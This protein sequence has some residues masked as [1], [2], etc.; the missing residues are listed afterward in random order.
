MHTDTIDH[1]I[2]MEQLQS[3]MGLSGTALKWFQSYI[4]HRI[5]SVLI[6]GTT[7][8]ILEL[9][10]GVPQGS[11]LGPLLF[12]IYTGPLGDLLCSLGINYHLYADDTQ[13]YLTFDLDDAPDMIKKIEN[14]VVLI[15]QWMT[16]NFLCLNEDKTEVLVLGS[17]YYLPK[18]SIPTVSI[19]NEQ[20]V[21]AKSARNIGFYFHSTMNLKKQ[22]GETC[23]AAWLLALPQG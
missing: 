4:Q 18:L 10:F 3:R 22:I 9:L 13:L 6:N 16:R 17:D 1:K 14:A 12:I 15:K 7:S 23:K 21:P 19:G 2:L 5:Q 8:S 20:I 11:V